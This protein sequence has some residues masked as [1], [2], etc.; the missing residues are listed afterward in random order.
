M[1]TIDLRYYNDN[2][3]N[4]IINNNIDLVIMAYNPSA[5]QDSIKKFNKLN[6]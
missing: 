1:N 3:R 4:Y 2:L 6:N 5:Y